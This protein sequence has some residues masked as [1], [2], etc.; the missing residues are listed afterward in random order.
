MSTKKDVELAAQIPVASLKIKEIQDGLL[1]RHM[2]EDARRLAWSQEYYKGQGDL[3]AAQNELQAAAEAEARLYMEV[4]VELRAGLESARSEVRGCWETI[5]RA[6]QELMSAQGQ[7]DRKIERSK[8]PD[9]DI[10]TKVQIEAFLDEIHVKKEALKA[11]EDVKQK[12]ESKSAKIK[13]EIDR[14]V[15]SIKK[16]AK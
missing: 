12:L 10:L 2:E 9:G 7:Y 1:K 15:A 8:K 14:T 16:A 4:P 5:G 13:A 6:R 3:R 11:Q